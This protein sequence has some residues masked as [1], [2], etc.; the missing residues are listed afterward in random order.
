MGIGSNRKYFWAYDLDYTSS[1][2]TKT[3]LTIYQAGEV[4]AGTPPEI[5]STG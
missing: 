1:K 3:V 5:Q 2:S 4:P